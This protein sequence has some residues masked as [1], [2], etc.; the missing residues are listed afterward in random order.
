MQDLQKKTVT[1]ET[2]SREYLMCKK[3]GNIQCTNNKI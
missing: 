1:Y 2:I 3:N